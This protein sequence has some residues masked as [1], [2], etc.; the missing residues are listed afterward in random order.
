MFRVHERDDAVEAEGRLDVIIDEKGLGHRR[1]VGHAS[2]L[3]HNP[4]QLERTGLDPLREIVEDHD[5]VLADGAA[6][7]PVHH[8]DD[9]LIG[10]HLSVLGEKCVI[11][12]HLTKLVLDDG[13][14]L[15][16]RL[17]EDVVEERRL[18]GTEEA[19]EHRDR[20][21]QIVRGV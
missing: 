12:A 13:E 10:L 6:D 16:V 19:R 21:L 17:S 1:R 11:D 2:G 5:E 15:S 4:V 9:L 3:D 18:A 20:A 14:L 7:A 8:L